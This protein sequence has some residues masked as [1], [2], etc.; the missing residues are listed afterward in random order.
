MVQ[1]IQMQADQCKALAHPVRLRILAL[2]EGEELC[3]CQMLA[4]L[5]NQ[6]VS[7]LSE[8]LSVL[9]RAGFV[10]E[11]KEIRRV[12]CRLNQAPD[13]APLLDLILQ[14]LADTPEAAADR[15]E[16]QRVKGEDIQKLSQSIYGS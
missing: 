14:R 15:H 10:L 5:G 3:V 1:S 13:I 11:R 6:A 4:A 8:H 12:F 7:S 16:L 2:L 9:R